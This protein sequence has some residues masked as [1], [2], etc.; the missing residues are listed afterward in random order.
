[1]NIAFINGHFLPSEQIRISP[2]DR[3]FL[4][5]DGVYEVVRWY[6][7]FFFD[8]ENHLRRLKRSMSEIRISWTESDSFPVIANKL[9]RLNDLDDRQAL[10]Y[11]QVT[12]GAAPRTHAFPSPAISPT[13]YAFASGFKPDNELMSDGIDVILRQDIRWSRCD[14][15]SVSLLPNII[16]FQEAVDQ[17]SKECIY[18]RNGV[19]TEGSHSNVFFIINGTLYTHP[20]SFMILSGITRKNVLRIARESG[21]P[22]L[23]EGVTESMLN[24]ISEAFITNTSSEIAPVIS[25]DGIKVGKGI[26]GPVTKLL[27]SKFRDE[28]SRLKG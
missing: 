26:P 25:I 19:I 1:M 10:V 2:D 8:I 11:L 18:I 23:E 3:G 14:I 7:G 16:T 20:E 28:I 15:K 22:V 13:V 5:G 27:R 4:F 24:E 9:I 21:V 6:Q 12:R 17:G